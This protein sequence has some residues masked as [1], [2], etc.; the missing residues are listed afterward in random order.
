MPA[1]RSE[2]AAASTSVV[3]RA[4]GIAL[5][6]ALL[7]ALAIVGWI[8]LDHDREAVLSKTTMEWSQPVVVAAVTLWLV[9]ILV[10]LSPQWPMQ[11]GMLMAIK[12][13]TIVAAIWMVALAAVAIG[14]NPGAVIVASAV[15]YA[16]LGAVT[17]SDWI[18]LTGPAATFGFA[19]T[20]YF[21]GRLADDP[22]IIV[23]RDLWPN[24]ASIV[25]VVVGPVLAI[26]ALV[27]ISIG[28]WIVI[29]LRDR[30]G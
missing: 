26:V 25:G 22:S 16:V 29:L 11:R 21:W 18:F 3:L 19:I 30:L 7:L 2:P 12:D 10:A 6:I 9:A 14:I 28:R 23:E 24:Y 4:A 1:H 17:D 15:A 20:T 27:L 13:I 8:S 5:S